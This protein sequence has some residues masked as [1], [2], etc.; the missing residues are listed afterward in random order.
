MPDVRRGKARSAE[1]CRPDGVTRFAGSLEPVAF[2]CS[3]QVSRY[4]IEPVEGSFRR[5]LLSKERCRIEGLDELKPN[6]PEVAVV[7]EG[8]LL[9]RVREWLARAG[10]R[11]DGSVVRPTSGPEREVP[12]AD[13][14]EEF[15]P[16]RVSG[17]LSG[18]QSEVRTGGAQSWV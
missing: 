7:V 8:L 6:R 14:G 13:P 10:S 9:A 5:N 2:A 17:R 11:P 4:K 18:G 12:T 16:V 15:A 3:L 1:I